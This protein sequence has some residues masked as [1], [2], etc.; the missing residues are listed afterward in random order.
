MMQLS[1]DLISFL[2]KEKKNKQKKPINFPKEQEAEWSSSL[3]N[4]RKQAWG[5]VRRQREGVS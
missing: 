2:Q 1:Y 3:V 4:E 5:V